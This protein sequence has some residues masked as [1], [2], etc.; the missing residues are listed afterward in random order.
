MG[1]VSSLTKG[2][3][4]WLGD[5]P[6]L[7]RLSH[8][9]IVAC[10][11]HATELR[12]LRAI[13]VCEMKFSSSSVGHRVRF[14]TRRPRVQISPARPKVDRSYP[15]SLAIEPGPAPDL[16][17]RWV[18]QRTTATGF[19]LQDQRCVPSGMLAGA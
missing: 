10:R 2:L 4:H 1:F 19:E 12:D 8:A 5:V 13:R 18:A 14:G 6:D 9:L 15:N 7:K 16:G 11:L 17:G 3:Q